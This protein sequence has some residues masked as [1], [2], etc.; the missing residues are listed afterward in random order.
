MW[1][2]QGPVLLLQVQSLT[3]GLCQVFAAVPL[4]NW[5]LILHRPRNG[6]PHWNTIRIPISWIFQ[7]WQQL[8][9]KSSISPFMYTATKCSLA[10]LV[11][12][13][14][15]E[16]D[17]CVTRTSDNMI[18]LALSWASTHSC[19]SSHLL[20]LTVVWFYRVICVTTS[21]QGMCNSILLV[22]QA[23]NVAALVCDVILP[24]WTWFGD[25]SMTNQLK[26]YRQASQTFICPRC[27]NHT[28]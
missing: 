26:F 14:L 6:M 17:V 19:A 5:Q 8:H 28:H 11:L 16:G 12:A 1:F 7:V 23:D 20:I 2:S 21:W 24:L 13:R 27:V 15:V 22:A 10:L 3:M 4:D 18:G 25:L 9:T